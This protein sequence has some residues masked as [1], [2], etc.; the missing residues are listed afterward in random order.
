MSSPV[1]SLGN[2]VTSDVDFVDFDQIF[3][4]TDLSAGGGGSEPST[5]SSS[6]GS[7]GTGSTLSSE[8][9]STT[10]PVGS[11]FFPRYYEYSGDSTRPAS[12]V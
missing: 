6:S 3:D 2:S 7:G 5:S 12:F 11:H 10:Y 8:E 1:S 4:T 9:S